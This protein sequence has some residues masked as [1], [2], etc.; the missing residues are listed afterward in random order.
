MLYGCITYLATSVQQMFYAP[1]AGPPT[2]SPQR[3][4]AQLPRAP[5]APSWALLTSTRAQPGFG[6]LGRKSLIEH[7][8]ETPGEPSLGL[9][10][11]HQQLAAKE[12]VGAVPWLAREVEMGGQHAAPARLHLHMDMARAGGISAGHHAAESIAPLRLPAT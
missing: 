9:G 8:V 11:A 1:L 5:L 4:P 3:R 12:A 7:E 6:T 2:L 10:C